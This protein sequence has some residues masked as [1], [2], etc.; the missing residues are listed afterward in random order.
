[1][2]MRLLVPCFVLALCGLL[3]GCF[4]ASR[5][6]EIKIGM[7]KDQVVTILGKPDST[8]AQGNIEYL[9]YYLAADTERAGDQPYSVR[10]V[11]GQVESFGRFTQLFDIYN[12]PVNGGPSPTLSPTPAPNTS[13]L[14]M[15]LQRLKVLHDQGVL[16]DEEFQR[17]KTKLLSQ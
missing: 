14:A 5:L 1:M 13:S 6:N 12:R 3:A 15:E 10:L 2:K 9:T 16:N 11:N 8:S 4:S 7:S 17:A